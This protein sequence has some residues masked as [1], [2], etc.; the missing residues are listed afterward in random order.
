[1]ICQLVASFPSFLALDSFHWNVLKEGNLRLSMVQNST[2]VLSGM[3]PTFV[4]SYK[5]NS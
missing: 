2:V 4:L 1:M 5:D 3:T